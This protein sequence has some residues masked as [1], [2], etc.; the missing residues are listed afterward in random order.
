MG[1]MARDVRDGA[2]LLQVIAG[3]DGFDPRAAPAPAD[4]LAA[5]DDGVDG[6]RFAFSADVGHIAVEPQVARQVRDCAAGLEAAGA[7]ILAVDTDLGDA[8]P[9]L[10][11]VIA[12]DIAAGVAVAYLAGR[13]MQ[14]LR[15]AP[16]AKR[17]S[18][19]P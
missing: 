17:C 19:I 13:Q 1:P 14:E 7:A 5:L 16:E 18:A 8:W 9:W 15:S 3:T 2:M 10:A 4:Y 11:R 6:M 12:A